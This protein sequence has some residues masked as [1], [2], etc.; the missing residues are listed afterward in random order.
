MAIFAFAERLPTSAT[1]DKYVLPQKHFPIAIQNHQMII[2]PYRH[3]LI[4]FPEHLSTGFLD[5]QRIIVGQRMCF[6]KKPLS[7]VV[8]KL[9]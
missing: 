2:S 6:E 3:E 4:S 5:D 1:L 9:L 8:H 7:G